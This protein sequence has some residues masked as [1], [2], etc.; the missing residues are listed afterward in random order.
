MKRSF[1]SASPASIAAS[2]W[3]RRDGGY[4][5]RLHDTNGH[6]GKVEVTL[7]MRATTCE[8]VDFN[9][10]PM[11]SPAMRLSDNV[12]SF[13]MGAWEIVTLRFTAES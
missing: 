3:L 13:E 6:G 2:S 4:E 9:G 8:A 12:V 1:V 7:P 10:R 5:I 11:K